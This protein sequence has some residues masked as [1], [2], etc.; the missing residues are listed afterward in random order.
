MD[1]LV[2]FT[3]KQR[4]FMNLLF[5]LLMVIGAFTLLRMPLERYPNIQFGKMYVNTFLPGASPEEVENRVTKEIE[6]ALEDMEEIEFVSSSSYRERSNIVIKFN[7]DS[8]Y[9]RRFDDVRLKILSVLDE[10]P[11][12]TETPI[13]NFLD[14]NDWFPTISVNVAGN[15]SNTTL[16]LVADE[17]KISLAQLDGVQEVKVSGEYTRE[18]HLLLSAEK[19]RQYGVTIRQAADAIRTAGVTIR[20]EMQKQIWEN[21]YSRSMS[22][23]PQGKIFSG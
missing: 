18:F 19:L 1:R 8:D 11:E 10:L 13:F 22:S 17:I 7:D 15:H 21:L 5:V 4:V 16:S 2:A 20:R 9:R 12:E 3:L 23:L 6:K 14:V